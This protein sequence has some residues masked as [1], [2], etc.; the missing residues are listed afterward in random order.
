[1]RSRRSSATCRTSRHTHG[2]ATT[3]TPPRTATTASGAFANSVEVVRQQRPRAEQDQPDADERSNA[4]TVDQIRVREAPEPLRAVRTVA[5]R[6]E[7]GRTRHRERGRPHDLVAEPQARTPRDHQQARHDERDRE[8]P[9]RGRSRRRSGLF[10]RVRPSH[11]EEQPEVQHDAGAAGEREDHER[12]PD[13]QGVDA[14]PLPQPSGHAREDPVARA[15]S[16]AC[17]LSR[18]HRADASHARP[19]MPSGTSR[20]G[21]S[22]HP[23]RKSGSSRMA[24][25]ASSGPSSPRM[26]ETARGGHRRTRAP[27]GAS[28]STSPN[29]RASPF[30]AR[31]AAAPPARPR[32]G[33]GGCGR[34]AR[35]S[36]GHPG[37][38]AAAPARDRRVPV[39]RDLLGGRHRKRLDRP[40]RGSHR[41]DRPRIDRCDD[42][43]RRPVDRRAARGRHA[44]ARGAVH[45]TGQPP[46]VDQ[47]VSEHRVD[48]GLRAPRDR[49]G[50][51]RGSARHLGARPVPCRR[52]HRARRVALPAR[53]SG[54]LRG[55]GRGSKRGSKRGWR[56][57]GRRRLRPV[58]G[59][60]A[61]DPAAARALTA[62]MDHVRRRAAHRQRRRDLDEP[63]RRHTRHGPAGR[64]PRADLD[65]PGDRSARARR[66]PARRLG[67][68]P[69]EV[70][71]PARRCSSCR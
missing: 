67:V 68:R 69:R 32:E 14:E 38:R 37:A 6:P 66:G 10:V 4:R 29:R 22:R 36:L 45:R 7:H 57:A 64:R 25:A 43:L 35:R 2:P 5:A 46:A 18:R 54:T 55:C 17:L 71:D 15:P 65:D 60:G 3:A 19:R 12:Q 27:F 51:P 50:D 21:R 20:R 16:R 33:R 13:H 70:A 53:P 9:L 62:R 63:C 30:P 31:S 26:D 44:F 11:D 24:P 1:M 28:R 61:G 23:G 41:L 42:R 34:R 8:R 58:D 49:R 47:A 39:R 40:V 48:P 59:T 56:R 52:A